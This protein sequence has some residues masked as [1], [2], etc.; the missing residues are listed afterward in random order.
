LFMYADDLN[1]IKINDVEKTLWCKESLPLVRKI[2]LFE[3]QH[4]G[5][6]RSRFNKMRVLEAFPIKNATFK[7]YYNAKKAINE[8]E[9]LNGRFIKI[10]E[11]EGNNRFF[12]INSSC[13]AKPQFLGKKIPKE[14][15]GLNTKIN[16]HFYLTKTDYGYKMN[17]FKLKK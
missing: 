11:L 5:N 13:C 2:L 3:K 17:L 1:K 10:L 9:W 15:L 14:K 12:G 7:F 4:P 16:H 8:E 6:F